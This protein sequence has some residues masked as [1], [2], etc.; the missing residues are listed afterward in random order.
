MSV[1]LA[2][3]PDLVPFAPAARRTATVF[4][5]PVELVF[6]PE[7]KQRHGRATASRPAFVRSPAPRIVRD[8]AIWR[9]D[10]LVLTPNRYPFAQAHRILW[11]EAA[12]RDPDRAFWRALFDWVARSGGTA[13]V[14]NV[15]AAATIGRAHAHL[16]PESLP[17]LGALRERAVGAD[18]VDLPPHTALVAKDVPFGV[19]GVRGDPDARAAAM[20][21]LLEARL[22]PAWNVIAA[23]DTAWVVPRGIETPAP[24]YPYALGACELWGRWCYM[25]EAP[26]AAAS[27]A[28][29]ER[30]LVASGT[31]P[32]ALQG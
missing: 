16:V 14:N 27:G 5:A 24:H 8:E 15:G 28:D 25:D 18:L 22:T 29:L 1:P 32:L 26:F 3:H 2:P 13:L 11:P 4:G 19:L 6:V 17:F 9:G 31:A 12:V 21:A 10:G 20:V 30:A 23:G 7:R